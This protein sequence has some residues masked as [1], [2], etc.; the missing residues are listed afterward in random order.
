MGDSSASNGSNGSLSG[1]GEKSFEPF[2]TDVLAE[3]IQPT[4]PADLVAVLR[5]N[6]DEG[7]QPPAAIMHAA[8]EA[9]RILTEA[10]GAAL[11]LRTHGRIVCRARSGDPTPDL[12][13]PLNTDSGISG[14]CIRSAT[15]MVCH[16]AASDT[17]VDS[18]VCRA[19]D[20]NSIAVVPLRGPTGI[21]GILEVFSTHVSAF[22]EP[23]IDSLRALAE[24]IEVAY[25]R[26]VRGLQAKPAPPTKARPIGIVSV[27]AP[28][29][30]APAA[31]QSLT[32]RFWIIA[33]AI[34]VL[35]LAAGIWLGREPALETSAK[36]PPAAG[37]TAPADSNVAVLAT[38]GQP[39]PTQLKPNPGI[40]LMDRRSV[41]HP[42]VDRHSVD[43][44]AAEVVKQAAIVETVED[45][46]EPLRIAPGRSLASAAIITNRDN[47]DPPSV[48]SEPSATGTSANSDQ[49]S[50][51]AAASGPLPS[52]AAPVSQ[53][54]TPGKLIRKI[55]PVY[56]QAAKMQGVAGTVIVEM[57][58]SENGTVRDVKQI[59]GAPILAQAATD[60]IRKWRYSP[61]LLN[62][63]PLEVQKQ[64]S[65]VFKLPGN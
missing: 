2:L 11:A 5:Q 4:G 57:T 49:L 60:A 35:L 41:D 23:Q 63:K 45:Q 20:I 31:S 59:S 27:E 22:G 25:G 29:I 21:A 43:H 64:V 42:S 47:L 6:L 33:A 48:A 39:K 16:D 36:E 65:V 44:G 50:N 53:G 30:S 12:G 24:I 17:R 18:D 14:E 56:P 8:A 3:T 10:D 7:L 26:E 46:P 28:V 38:A 19:M 32:R 62:G 1:N 34:A 37:H 52:L 51:L 54:M 15:I 9:A 58:I 61:F 40:E 13:A 55:E